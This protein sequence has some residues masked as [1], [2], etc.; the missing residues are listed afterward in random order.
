LKKII[1][2]ARLKVAHSID[3]ALV[4]LYWRIG[5]RIQEDILKQKRAAYEEESR[6]HLLDEG[7]VSGGHTS[8]P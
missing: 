3:S 4:M 8:Q 2:Q 6:R 1:Q 7:K 5:K